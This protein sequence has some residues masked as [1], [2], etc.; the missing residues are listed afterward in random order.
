MEALGTVEIAVDAEVEPGRSRRPS[1]S[2]ALEFARE[3]IEEAAAFLE[4][5]EGRPFFAR[6]GGPT[7]LQSSK[8]G[9]AILRPRA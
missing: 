2:E 3:P 8:D 4:Q 9:A 6:A 5:V 1:Y 7:R